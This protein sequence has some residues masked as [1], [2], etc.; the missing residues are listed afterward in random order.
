M[1]N[2]YEVKLLFKRNNGTPRIETLSNIPKPSQMDEWKLYLLMA[3]NEKDTSR[4]NRIRFEPE[5]D[6][7]R[8]SGVLKSA[9]F[10]EALKIENPS[11]VMIPESKSVEPKKKLVAQDNEE[12]GGL[13]KS[14]DFMD[15][16]S[17]GPETVGQPSSIRSSS[18]PPPPSSKIPVPMAKKK[19][20][21]QG[22]EERASMRSNDLLD[23]LNEGPLDEGVSLT[24]I[25]SPKKIS[26]ASS[27]VNKAKSAKKAPV[28]P[29]KESGGDTEEP[30]VVKKRV[31]RD[32]YDID[33]MMEDIE[34]D[35]QFQDEEPPKR[36][37]KV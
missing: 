20:V 12:R 16:M 34:G 2:L 13:F 25:P 19:L 18:P 35:K 4:P 27:L 22:N 24:P 15:I 10:L 1:T 32:L 29:V 14:S 7:E 6:E 9:E 17:Q 21:A 33:Q 30:V 31:K 23:L 28:V 26:A 11:D 8:G 3:V 37:P 5:G 36:G